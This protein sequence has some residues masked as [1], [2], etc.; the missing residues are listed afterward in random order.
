M[1]L[2]I[3]AGGPDAVVRRGRRGN[4]T[5]C[6][7][8]ELCLVLD[9][10]EQAAGPDFAQILQASIHGDVPPRNGQDESAPENATG[11]VVAAF[12]AGGKGRSFLR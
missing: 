6:R 4:A 10:D 5:C 1:T 11:I 3:C 2:K 9:A 7:A 8:W 12:G